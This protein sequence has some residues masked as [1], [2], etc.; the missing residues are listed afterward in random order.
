M[1]I[2][3]S[4]V[5]EGRDNNFNL[6]RF[7]AAWGVLI[8][9]SYVI[10]SGD[11]VHEP[12][13]HWLGMTYGSLAVD[14]FFVTSGFLVTSSLI[15]KTVSGPFGLIA[16]TKAR[17]FRIYPALIVM[18][19]ATTVLLGF[20]FSNLPLAKYIQD[21]RTALYLV[22]NT[23]LFFGTTGTLPGVFDEVPF[24]RGV[25]GSLWTL[26]FEVR[27]YAALAGLWCLLQFSRL[28][29]RESLRLCV[30]FVTVA[31][32]VAHLHSALVEGAV[33]Q[34]RRLTFMFFCGAAY[35]LYRDKVTL[36]AR[37]AACAVIL[38][39]ISAVDRSAFVVA[40]HVLAGY[41]ILWLAYV[42]NG[43]IRLFNRLGDYSY[44]TYI[45][46]FPLQQAV[47]SVYPHMSIA[48]HMV[49]S[50]AITLVFATL[51]WHCIEEPSLRAVRSLNGMPAR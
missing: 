27:M 29:R 34:R 48:R 49:F 51:S 19:V 32:L 44:G 4:V 31:A 10:V 15:S 6:L 20:F 40:Y 17:A 50:T 11:S 7:L 22:K 8:S 12:L 13:Y 30:L 47:I 1:K 14:A 24:P 25:N 38:L 5:A 2:P 39:I 16:F 33:D 3:L 26:P 35:W 42:P 45:W 21:N 43:S 37:T 36:S 28:P 9:H 41:L 23:T 18:T 46:A